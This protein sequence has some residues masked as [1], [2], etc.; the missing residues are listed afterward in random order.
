MTCS[1]IHKVI[2]KSDGEHVGNIHATWAGDGSGGQFP[3]GVPH[4]GVL[5]NCY[6]FSGRVTQGALDYFRWDFTD[7]ALAASVKYT[8]EPSPF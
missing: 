5:V 4:G 1:I 8:F 2:R 3:D 7:A 6:R